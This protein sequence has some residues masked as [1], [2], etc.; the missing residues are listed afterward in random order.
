M[1]RALVVAVLMFGGL[2]LR[3]EARRS[4]MSIAVDSKS[5]GGWLGSLG[6]SKNEID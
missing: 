4:A 1:K 3:A 6:E 5:V 2:G